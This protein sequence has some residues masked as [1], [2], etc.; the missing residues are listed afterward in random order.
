VTKY[1]FNLSDREALAAKLRD[2]GATLREAAE[3]AGFNSPSA[4]GAAVARARRKAQAVKAL[5][6]GD[7]TAALSR[8]AARVLR[9]VA[10]EA[11]APATAA[12]VA[13][14]RAP[15]G[16]LSDAG[17][18]RW[19][20]LGEA[21]MRELCEWAGVEPPRALAISK[22]GPVE[23]KKQASRKKGRQT[24]AKDDRVGGGQARRDRQEGE[25]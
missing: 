7:A 23:G 12:T 21:T 11:G 2:G 5:A 10:A 15:G 8:R 1:W 13:E 18:R 3:A 4:A 9:A 19:R 24:Y 6:A 25:P 14:Q 17:W 22:A 16:G 20:N